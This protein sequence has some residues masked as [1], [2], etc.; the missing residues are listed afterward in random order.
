M[1][2]I[3]G[4]TGDATILSGYSMC[5]P[6]F[7]KLAI[8]MSPALAAQVA[9][10]GPQ[11]DAEYICEFDIWRF[12]LPRELLEDT[13]SKKC[14]FMLDVYSVI[15]LTIATPFVECS[16]LFDLATSL[17]TAR[18]L[19]IYAPKREEDKGTVGRNRVFFET[20]F[21]DTEDNLSVEDYPGMGVETDL[22]RNQRDK[23]I[24]FIEERIGLAA[25]K[26]RLEFQ[27]LKYYV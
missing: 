19:V 8:A 4:Q 16:P 6:D 15:L 11:P 14:V 3:I 12:R 27:V 2:V 5:W 9:K 18:A 23:F 25:D 24:E 20:R 21:I 13:H 1:S 22:D 26:S 10:E 17:A 7:Q